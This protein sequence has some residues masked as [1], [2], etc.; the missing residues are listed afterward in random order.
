M[1]HEFMAHRN[2]CGSGLIR[3]PENHFMFGGL[4]AHDTCTVAFGLVD[5]HAARGGFGQFLDFGLAFLRSAPPGICPP[6]LNDFL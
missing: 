4:P 1:R 6:I 5:R 2:N 3:L